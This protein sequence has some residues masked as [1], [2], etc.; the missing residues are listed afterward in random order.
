M[1]QEK[2][3]IY[4]KEIR[5]W[6]VS[7]T[8]KMK[9]KT[10]FELFQKQF[11]DVKVSYTSFKQERSVLGITE[12]QFKT[13]CRPLYSERICGGRLC[14]KVQMNPSKWV[15]KQSWIYKETH[16]EELN[17]IKP[18]DCFIFADGNT[19]NFAVEN[20]I[21]IPVKFMANFARLGGVVKG[22]AEG[23]RI[24]LARA[25]LNSSILDRLEDLGEV[26]HHTGSSRVTKEKSREAR[27]RYLEKIY[28]DPEK[29]KIYKE[30]MNER[31]KVRWVNLTEEK[32][33]KQRERAREWA[34]KK[35]KN[36]SKDEREEMYRKQREACAK[37]RATWT[38][39]DW[40]K[41]RA[42]KRAYNA[43]YKLL[44]IG[45]KKNEI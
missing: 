34:R 35:R 1:I 23:T 13:R 20:I 18:D 32:K 7:N 29:L 26:C 12:H 38:E 30:K 25:K 42:R 22:N 28:S 36:M 40:E 2:N 37:K 41:E 6:L 8:N 33:I 31:S 5:D 16:P 15:S 3:R 21:R 45:A 19:N 43:K 11:P 17:E 4:T 27:R 14:I 39:E 24:N 9:S 10:A 44:K